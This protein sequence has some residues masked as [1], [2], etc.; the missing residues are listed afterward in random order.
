MRL[1]LDVKMSYFE[2]AHSVCRLT[3]DGAVTSTVVVGFKK[4]K[5]PVVSSHQKKAAGKWRTRFVVNIGTKV[6]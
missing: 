5:A 6:K 1:K 4:R 3:Y 2:R